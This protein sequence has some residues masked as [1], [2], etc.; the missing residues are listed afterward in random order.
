LILDKLCF[1]G[2]RE[3]YWHDVPEEKIERWYGSFIQLVQRYDDIIN[4]HVRL[5]LINL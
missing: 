5:T 3:V 4:N 1:L 2:L